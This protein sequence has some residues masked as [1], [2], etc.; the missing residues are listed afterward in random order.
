MIKR[1]CRGVILTSFIL[2]SGCSALP[3]D[4]GNDR[5]YS[6]NDRYCDIPRIATNFYREHIFL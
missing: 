3:P 6:G 1:L 2:G 4:C 5:P